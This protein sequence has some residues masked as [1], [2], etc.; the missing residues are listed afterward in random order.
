M[1]ISEAFNGNPTVTNVEY[2]L[3]SASTTV[4][5]QTDDGI[6]QLFLDLNALTSTEEYRLRIY[7]KTQSSGTQ[8]VVQEV[9]FSGAQTE[10]IYASASLLLLHGW[11]FTLKKNQ[12]TDR[13]IPYS[14]RKVA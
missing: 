2:D 10:P 13:A 9:I 5:S 6:Y 4:S 8:R 12:G 11:T 7:E 1:A 3:P 14:I